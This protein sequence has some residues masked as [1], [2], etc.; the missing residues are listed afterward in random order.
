[1]RATRQAAIQSLHQQREEQRRESERIAQQ[2]I[3]SCI[4]DLVHVLVVHV[5]IY[6]L[7]ECTRPL[8]SG[9]PSYHS[10]DV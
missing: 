9:I 3:V 10:W 8:E 6:R 4:S 7:L 1:M 2:E 5:A